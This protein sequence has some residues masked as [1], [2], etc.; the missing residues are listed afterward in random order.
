MIQINFRLIVR[1]SMESLIEVINR[2]KNEVGLNKKQ[3]LQQLLPNKHILK[4]LDVT[5]DKFGLFVTK[6]F[7]SLR[8]NESEINLNRKYYL[9]QILLHNRHLSRLQAVN[10]LKNK[11]G[12]SGTGFQQFYQRYG[13]ELK[14]E[15]DK[16]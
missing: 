14:T 15:M 13:R 8:L 1:S 2:L 9:Y 5:E 3:I 10:S 12:A 16:T 11:F 7:K 6:I 4:I